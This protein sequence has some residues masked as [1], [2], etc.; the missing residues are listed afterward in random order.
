MSRPVRHGDAVSIGVRRIF[1][2]PV[3]TQVI[4]F[5]TLQHG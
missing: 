3:C 1:T 5:D 2:A 4:A